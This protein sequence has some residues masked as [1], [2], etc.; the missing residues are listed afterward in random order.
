M[1]SF[2]LRSQLPLFKKNI[3]AACKKSG[4]SYR[5]S[6]EITLN[7]PLDSYSIIDGSIKWNRED[8]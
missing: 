7:N 1:I 5:D 2:V 3:R 4:L 6:R 8:A